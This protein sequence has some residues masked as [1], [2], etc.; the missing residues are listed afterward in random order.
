VLRFSRGADLAIQELERFA[1]PLLRPNSNTPELLRLWLCKAHGAAARIA[2]VLHGCAAV[3]GAHQILDE[4][5][6]A[7]AAAAV[8]IVKDYF[9]PHARAAFGLMSA[10]ARVTELRHALRLLRQRCGDCGDLLGP[11]SGGSGPAISER[12]IFKACEG[13]WPTME[14]LR[15]VLATLVQH[16]Y[17]RPLPQQNHPGPGRKSSPLYEVNPLWLASGE[18]V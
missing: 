14:E 1:Q 7:T 18:E 17:L 15:P 2:G 12:D 11:A 9:L 8:A 10:P 6:E 3:T 16:N 13:R 5:S 4:V